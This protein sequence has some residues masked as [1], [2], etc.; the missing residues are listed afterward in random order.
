MSRLFG[1][2][3]KYNLPRWSILIID[4]VICVFSLTLAFFLRFNF[5]R[6]PAED[7]KNFPADYTILIVIRF[8]SFFFSKTYKGVVR[9]TGSR[10]AMRIFGVVIAGS[11]LMVSVN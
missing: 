6:I 10:D 4:L 2:F 1:L 3:W 7:L 5:A 9:Y 8:L 11:I